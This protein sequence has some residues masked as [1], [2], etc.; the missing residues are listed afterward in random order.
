MLAAAARHSTLTVLNVEGN[1]GSRELSQAAMAA[2]QATL[3]D[4]R[5]LAAERQTATRQRQKERAQPP[6]ARLQVRRACG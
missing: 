2:L 1:P 4:H 3:G 5:R 6:S